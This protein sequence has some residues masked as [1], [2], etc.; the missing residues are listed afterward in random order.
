M[1]KF[2]I[3]LQ[4]IGVIATVLST[5]IGYLVLINDS[6]YSE[7]S[8]VN[9]IKLKVAEVVAP[10]GYTLNNPKINVIE[11]NSYFSVKVRDSAYLFS[12]EK[13]PFSVKKGYTNRVVLL[14]NGRSMTVSLGGT[15]K[16]ENTGC[17]FWL[18]SIE[19]KQYNMELKCK[20]T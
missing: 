5:Y 4:L 1:T 15:A 10:K 20:E 16:I 7:E 12:D 6:S 3:T 13:I 17:R 14:I 11:R 18:Y 2:N 8:S 19:L 9:T